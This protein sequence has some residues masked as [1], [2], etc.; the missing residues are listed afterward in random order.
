[1]SSNKTIIAADEFR[2][3]PLSIIPGGSKI[4]I[5]YEKYTIVYQ[6]I[7]NPT[8]YIN[9]IEVNPNNPIISIKVDGTQYHT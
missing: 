9:A 8:A 1:M 3:N 2:T 4:E 5:I 6:N 7:K